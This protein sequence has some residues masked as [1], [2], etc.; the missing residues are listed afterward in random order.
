MIIGISVNGI[1]RDTLVKIREIYEKYEET[2]ID[3]DLTYSNLMSKLNFETQ[4]DLYNFLYDESPIEIF[5]HAMESETNVINKFNE[6]VKNQIDNEIIIISDEIGKS[7]PATLFFLSKYG[8]LVSEIFFY[9]LNSIHKV[10][11]KCD[12]I[13]TDS[14]E[15]LKIKPDNKV[16]I[17]K[18]NTDN[19]EIIS[20]YI[21]NNFDEFL[22]LDLWTKE[23]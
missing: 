3:G 21:V 15:I 14:N 5:G 9:N 20:D 8:T 18:L 4:E 17:K 7:K 19:N 1:L 2:T 12:V 22:N 13:L 10:W 16:V 6:F 23:K 11:E